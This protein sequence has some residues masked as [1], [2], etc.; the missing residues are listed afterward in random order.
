MSVDPYLVEV[1]RGA[2]VESRHRGAIAI[3]D[4][5]GRAVFATGDTGQAAPQHVF[6]R[7]SMA[8]ITGSCFRGG[9]SGT[10]GGGDPGWA[11]SFMT[12]KVPGSRR[13]PWLV[14]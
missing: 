9:P 3:V 10:K 11:I 6:H 14:T 2:F 7:V 4:A 1:T 12:L 8:W 13:L 5:K